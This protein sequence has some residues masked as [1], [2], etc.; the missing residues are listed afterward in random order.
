MKMVGGFGKCVGHALMLT[1]CKK[2]PSKSYHFLFSLNGTVPAGAPESVHRMIGNC[3]CVEARQD[4]KTVNPG[5]LGRKGTPSPRNLV[6]ISAIDN[7]E[8]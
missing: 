1:F 4:Q 7:Q 8:F 5:D 2:R 3:I 6:E